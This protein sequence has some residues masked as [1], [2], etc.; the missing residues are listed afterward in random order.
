MVKWDISG[1]LYYLAQGESFFIPA[2]NLT[3]LRANIKKEA[4]A[5][6]LHVTTRTRVEGGLQG[7]RTWLTPN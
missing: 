6:G 1:A 7:V 3:R 5:M 4:K 2:V